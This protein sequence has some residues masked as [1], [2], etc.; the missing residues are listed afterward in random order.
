MDANNIQIGGSH[1]RKGY[2]HWDFVA[3][4]NMPYHLACATK[5]VSRWR[6]K[7]GV[8]DLAKAHHYLAKARERGIVMPIHDKVHVYAFAKQFDEQEKDIILAICDNSFNS[9][10]ELISKM[11]ISIGTLKILL[12]IEAEAEPTRNYVDPDHNYIKG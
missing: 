4:T 11:G 8:E 10:L 3:D 2:Q 5:Y 6:E 7:N 9:A 12:Q 1:Y